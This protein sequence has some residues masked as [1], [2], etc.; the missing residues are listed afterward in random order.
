M[1][2]CLC[3]WSKL[4]HIIHALY[5]FR[6]EANRRSWYGCETHW[7]QDEINQSNN[8][9]SNQ[10]S[11]LTNQSNDTYVK[12]NHKHSF[13]K[14]SFK[15]YTKQL[16]NIPGQVTLTLN[17]AKDG[18]SNEFTL[19]RQ[20]ELSQPITS[21]GWHSSRLLGRRGRWLSTEQT[22]TSELLPEQTSAP[23]WVISTHFRWIS[24]DGTTWHPHQGTSYTT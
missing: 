7:L 13:Y 11:Q 8:Q 23:R 14:V 24:D 22:H 5:D 2:V 9:S 21:A 3:V 18:G 6:R 17:P 19:T 10:I 20:G 16:S 12:D 4:I 15:A 1:C